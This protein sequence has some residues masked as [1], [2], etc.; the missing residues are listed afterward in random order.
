VQVGD[1]DALARA[2]V[3]LL[4]DPDRCMRMGEAGKVAVLS[5]RGALEKLLGVLTD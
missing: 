5:N 1:G 3:E 4:D 2:L